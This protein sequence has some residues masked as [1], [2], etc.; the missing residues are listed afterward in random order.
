M[1]SVEKIDN[2]NKNAFK[3]IQDNSGYLIE[4]TKKFG[5]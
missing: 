2:E 1:I 3:D 4:E 5:K